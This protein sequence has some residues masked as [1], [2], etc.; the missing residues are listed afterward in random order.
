[1]EEGKREAREASLYNIML[2]Q[3]LPYEMVFF[4][5]D[6]WDI[7]ESEQ[8]KIEKMARIMKEFPDEKFIILGAADSKTGTPGHNEFLSHNRAD[9]VYNMLVTGYGID[10]AQLHREYLGGILEF[11]PFILNRTTI[12]I[13][14]HPTVL[15]EFQKMK[16]MHKAGGGAVEIDMKK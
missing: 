13:M 11:E 14:D 8:M 6:K 1:M 5:L 9:V 12:I 3:L 4:E 16:A 15:E 2:K 10:T 7:L